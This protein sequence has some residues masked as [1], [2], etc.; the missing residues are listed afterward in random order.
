MKPFGYSYLLDMYNCR[1]G[2]AD[3]LELHYRFLE[4]LVDEIGMTRMSQPF[5]IHG[6]TQNGVELYPEKAGVS[7][8]VPLIES[9]IQIH[10][11][12]PTHFITLDVYSCNYFDKNVILEFSRKWFGFEQYEEHY[13]VRGVN[14]TNTGEGK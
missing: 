10:S 5:V 7:G 2:V 9:G 11:L 1:T 14:F 8:W 6:P 12:E 13:V 3:D 4:K